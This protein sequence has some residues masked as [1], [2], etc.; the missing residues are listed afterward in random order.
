MP[1]LTTT[2]HERLLYGRL[3]A[4][5]VLDLSPRAID[6]LIASGDI[7]AIRIGKRVLI[8][9]DSLRRFATAERARIRPK[10]RSAKG[11]QDEQRA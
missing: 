1:A 6:Y 5:V 7:E 9:A 3:S 4:A 11:E 2:L 8:T 10:T